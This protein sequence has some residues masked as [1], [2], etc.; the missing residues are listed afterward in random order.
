M[1]V[2]IIDDEET[3]RELIRASE[4]WILLSDHCD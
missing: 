3:M 2:I 4:Q 1:K